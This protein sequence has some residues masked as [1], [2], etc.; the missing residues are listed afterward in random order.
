MSEKDIQ[1]I[2]RDTAYQ[3][4][5][6]VK[7]EN[8]GFAPELRTQLKEVIKTQLEIK[9]H[10]V[11]Q[12]KAH[13]EQKTEIDSMK[14]IIESWKWGGKV[15]IGTFAVLGGFIAWLLSAFGIHLGLR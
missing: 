3:V 6:S 13:Q 7:S 14:T 2:I 10:L 9:E 12:D 11:M 4:A 1:Q 15:A 8:S 5:Q